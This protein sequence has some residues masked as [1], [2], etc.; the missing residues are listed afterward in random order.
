ML[1]DS[2]LVYLKTLDTVINVALMGCIVNGPGEAREADIGIAGGIGEA[3][4]ISH[5]EIIGKIPEGDIVEALIEKI[6][7]IKNKTE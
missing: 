2:E 6:K 7:E 1:A 4:M 5:G 3:V